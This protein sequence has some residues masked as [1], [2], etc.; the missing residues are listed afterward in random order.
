MRAVLLLVVGVLTGCFTAS[1]GAARAQEAANEFNLQTRFGRMELAT[2]KL[3]PSSREELLKHR[4]GWG[5]R[6]RI[7]DVETAGIRMLGKEGTEA[8]VAV[9]VSWFRPDEGELRT[10]VLK[11]KWR[12]YQGDWR[13]FTEERADGDIGLVG[14][15]ITREVE[16]TE[17]RPSQFPTIKLTGTVD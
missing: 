10:T 1:A 2:E 14:E 9:K 7:A 5:T 15:A 3:A 4:I 12:D 11:Q 6:I 13:L 16:R 17:A 8:E